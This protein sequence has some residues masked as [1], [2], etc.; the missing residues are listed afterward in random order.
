[1][2]DLQGWIGSAGEQGLT[3]ADLIAR[4]GRRAEEI[5]SRLRPL[6]ESNTVTSLGETYFAADAA[7]SLRTRA[8]QAVRDFHAKNRFAA[9]VNADELRGVLS[10][11]PAAFAALINAL[12][13]DAILVHEGTTIKLRGAGVQLEDAE[14]QAMQQIVNAFASAG[15]KVPALPEVLGG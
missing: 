14:T 13:Q 3:T 7:R 2:R 1:L 11:Q 5:S 15:L 6:M 9:G 8:E 4:S 12:Q 10:L